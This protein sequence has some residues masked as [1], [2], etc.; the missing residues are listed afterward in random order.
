MGKKLDNMDLLIAS[1]A[2]DNKLTLVTGN[3]RHYERIP[4]LKLL[5]WE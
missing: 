3:R 5:V 1:I 2:I 4:G